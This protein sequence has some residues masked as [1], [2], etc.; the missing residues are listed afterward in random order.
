MK[1]KNGEAIPGPGIQ[2]PDPVDPPAGLDEKIREK[3]TGPGLDEK[4]GAAPGPAGPGIQEKSGGFSRI[5]SEKIEPLPE[6]V[7]LSK[8]LIAFPF[9]AWAAAKRDESKK[10]T[11]KEIDALGN[12]LAR[13]MVKYQLDEYAKDEYVFFLYLTY[14]I[15]KRYDFKNKSITAGDPIGSR[16]PNPKQDKPGPINQHSRPAGDGENIPYPPDPPGESR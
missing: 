7:D 16:E 14:A 5:S 3:M 11:D 1:R 9:E 6:V 12:R 13:I 8:D 15:A 4:L 2:G 10:L